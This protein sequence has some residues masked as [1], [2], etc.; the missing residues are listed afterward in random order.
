MMSRVHETTEP[1]S[2]R[3]RNIVSM[4][5]DPGYLSIKNMSPERLHTELPN[6]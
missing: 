5:A 2:N 4:V 6:V 1:G 3:Q